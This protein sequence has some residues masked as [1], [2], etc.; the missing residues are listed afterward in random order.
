MDSLCK[1]SERVCKKQK[2][3]Y[4]KT[5]EAIEGLLREVEGARSLILADEGADHGQLLRDLQKRIHD[6]K[7]DVSAVE[8]IQK[9]FHSCINKLGKTMDKL[10]VPNIAK[11]CRQI[12][13]EQALVDQVVA[14]HLYRE[15]R[16]ELGDTFAAEAGVGSSDSL[17]E[18]F[19]EMHEVL[20]DL[21][22]RRL[23]RALAWVERHR[24]ALERGRSEPAALEFM[25]HRLQYVH[26]L[27]G[28]EGGGR[29][30]ALRYGRERFPPFARSQ[31]AQIQRLMGALLY[32][33]RLGESPYADLLAGGFWEELELQFARECCSLLGQS[34]DSPLAV[35]VSAGSRALPVLLKLAGILAS[36]SQEMSA[37]DQLPVEIELGREFN[38]HSVFACPVSRDQS[39]P[40]NPPMLLP[41]GHVLA[42]QSIQKLAKSSNRLFKCPY[43]PGE[44]TSGECRE[45]TF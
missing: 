4:Q 44:T 3:S 13:F 24:A 38:F 36:K 23:G 34:Y 25:I 28:G 41:C 42:K 9:E 37:L 21:R 43:C 26:L 6:L 40:E 17:K 33:G 19:V 39:T 2:T 12:T 35:V 32:A 18:T 45:L 20:E 1:E 27:G 15:G 16:F 14:Q 31:L 8:G 10:M 30:E 11:A 5:S 29:L 7:L 22:G